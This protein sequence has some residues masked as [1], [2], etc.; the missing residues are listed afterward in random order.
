MKEK[1]FKHPIFSHFI[2]R[3]AL[4]KMIED[5]INVLTIES[6][7]VILLVKRNMFIHSKWISLFSFHSLTI[8]IFILF[9]SFRFVVSP[10]SNPFE[11]CW[12]Q[13]DVIIPW[14]LI[15]SVIVSVNHEN[16]M[17][18]AIC[19]DLVQFPKITKCG[20]CFW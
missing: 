9:F 18:C 7:V 14:D 2:M 5:L 10:L 12:Y 6:I 17:I 19:L 3:K 11:S 16:T 13:T 8:V 1:E 20:H 4:H 15:E